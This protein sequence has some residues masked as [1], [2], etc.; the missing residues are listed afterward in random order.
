MVD[1]YPTLAELTG[2][3]DPRSEGELL[4]GTS[5]AP[6]FDNPAD[7]TIKSAAFSQFAKRYGGLDGVTDINPKFTRAETSFM[8]YT[9]RVPN[10]RYTAWFNFDNTTIRPALDEVI[11][12]ELYD[13]HGDTGLWLD[14]PG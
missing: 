1:V 8:G 13:H 11:G 4:N 14:F 2:L 6:V 7:V 3:P 5:L 9:I 10:W 12:R